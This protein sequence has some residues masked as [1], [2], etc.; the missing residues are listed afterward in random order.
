MK[1]ETKKQYVIVPHTRQDIHLQLPKA[2]YSEVSLSV[3][4][5]SEL[6]DDLKK[7]LTVCKKLGVIK[8]PP[9]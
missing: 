1:N 5:A 9:V 7:A 4:E 2:R 6:I 3:E 8:P